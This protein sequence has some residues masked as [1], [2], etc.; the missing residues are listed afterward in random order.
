MLEGPKFA[1]ELA[2]IKD[3]FRTIS[4]DNV[5]RDQ[6]LPDIQRRGLS[7]VTTPTTTSVNYAS[8]LT[9][10]RDISTT[11]SPLAVQQ[12]LNVSQPVPSRAVWQNRRGERIDPSH[13][14]KLQD[15]ARLAHRKL[16]NNFHLLGKCHFFDKYGECSHKHGEALSSIQ[17]EMLRVIARKSPCLR[18]LSCDDPLCILGHQCTRN[19]C[20]P[21][22]CRFRSDMHN[23]D[24]TTVF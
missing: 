1:R 14:F 19:D 2:N 15:L 13:Q 8:A 5:F 20:V 12:E 6:K 18:G 24:T 10:G 4:F 11:V 23:V 16:C 9:Q 17:T 7:H 22:N 3:R 21:S